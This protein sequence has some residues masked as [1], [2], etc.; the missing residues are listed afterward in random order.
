MPPRQ[1]VERRLASEWMA[2]SYTGKVYSVNYPLGPLPPGFTN[3]TDAMPWLR[4]VDGLAV[5]AQAIDL[6]EFKVWKPQDGLD[7]LPVYKLAIPHTPWLG[8]AK[9][10]P[11]NMIL[12]TPRSNPVIETNA[13]LQ[14]IKLVVVSGGWID[15]V[16]AHIEWLWT[17]EG[18]QFM[19]E[20][21][22]QRAW[23]GLE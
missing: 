9:D 8:P 19:A 16:V 13:K 7:K 5:L 15:D 18:R 4:K 23:L 3:M 14:G 6:V 17:A 11:V 10:Y 20:R 22:K 1:S 21:A 2:Q 12:V